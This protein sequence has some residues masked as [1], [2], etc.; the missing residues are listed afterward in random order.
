MTPRLIAYIRAADA[1]QRAA[2]ARAAL[3]P[4]SSRARVT[5]ANAR[6]SSQAEERDRL[7]RDLPADFVAAVD[8]ALWRGWCHEAAQK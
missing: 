4:G 1:S 2:V 7:A 3:P 6:W 5:S 8:A